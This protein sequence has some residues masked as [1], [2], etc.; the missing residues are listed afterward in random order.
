VKVLSLSTYNSGG[1]YKAAKVLCDE[2]GNEVTTASM[3]TNSIHLKIRNFLDA[4]PKIFYT[5]RKLEIFSASIFE[6]G[7]NHVNINRLNPDLVHLHWFNKGML[8]IV[9]LAKIEKPIIWTLHDMWAFTGGCHYT[10]NCTRYLQL[11]GECPQLGSHKIQDWSYRI[12]QEKVKFFQNLSIHLVSPSHWLAQCVH[13]SGLFKKATLSVI[14]NGLNLKTY[15]PQ[16]KAQVRSKFNLPA[17]QP[18]ILFGAMNLNEVRKGFIL[19]KQALAIL[20]NSNIVSNPA[21]LT[22]GSDIPESESLGFQVYS[23][24]FISSENHLAEIYSA[25]DVFVAPSL[26]DNLPNTVM[27]S[28]ACGTPVV[29]F[30]IGGMPDM[31]EHQK[32]GYLAKPYDVTDLAHGIE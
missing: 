9:T 1:A 12:Q 4:Y 26:Q 22:F 6:G 16:G 23:M 18:L 28:L 24:G 15:S 20:K 17:E 3:L 29:A 11:C 14:P 5:K 32:N 25:A 27:E 8:S 31:I 30:D 13:A 7:V 10:G 19:L 21:L 2:L